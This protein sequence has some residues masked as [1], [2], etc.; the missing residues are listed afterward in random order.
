M[1]ERLSK[2]MRAALVVIITLGNSFSLTPYK[3]SF[4]IFKKNDLSLPEI[5][6]PSNLFDSQ[7]EW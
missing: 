2:A 3:I 7:I 5:Y 1:I 6:I 4:H